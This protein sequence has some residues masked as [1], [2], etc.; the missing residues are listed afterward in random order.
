M[1]DEAILFSDIKKMC[2]LLAGYDVSNFDQPASETEIAEFQQKNNLVLP[3]GL[4]NLYR[5]SNG[6]RIL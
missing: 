1:D 4:S 5:I 2:G 6:F 3:V